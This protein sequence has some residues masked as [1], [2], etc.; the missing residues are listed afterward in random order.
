MWKKSQEELFTT[1]FLLT[2]LREP[3][4]QKLVDNSEETE[5][6]TME[7]GT[8]YTM[9][10]KYDDILGVKRTFSADDWVKYEN[11]K[12]M[13]RDFNKYIAINYLLS[14]TFP[15]NEETA[16]D[17]DPKN[18]KKHLEYMEKAYKL[19]KNTIETHRIG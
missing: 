1:K 7:D 11:F 8:K 5:E 2:K 13:I 14:I 6:W 16:E 17:H 12:K 18:I 4:A 19:I 15:T 10:E 9:I 3:E